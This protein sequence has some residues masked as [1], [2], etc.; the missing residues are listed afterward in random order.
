VW[1]KSRTLAPTPASPTLLEAYP[2]KSRLLFML[3]K[4]DGELMVVVRTGLHEVEVLFAK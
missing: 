2:N 1:L 3:G 4:D